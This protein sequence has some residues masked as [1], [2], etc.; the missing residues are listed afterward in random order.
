MAEDHAMAEGKAV[1]DDAMA[2]GKAMA[3]DEAMA[4][5]KPMKAEE[6]MAKEDVWNQF[7][8]NFMA[9]PDAKVEGENMGGVRM[10]RRAMAGVKAVEEGAKVDV[11]DDA[12]SGMAVVKAILLLMLFQK[13]IA[14]TTNN[15]Q[16]TTEPRATTTNC[17]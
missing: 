8:D 9:E 2:E 15:Q 14:T 17:C 10:L 3:K 16:P 1:Q 12:P 7:V 6:A 5:G 11:D 4:E 13:S